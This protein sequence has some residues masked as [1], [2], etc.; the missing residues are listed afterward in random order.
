[1]WNVEWRNIENVK[2]REKMNYASTN[3]KKTDTMTFM[4]DKVDL[5]KNITS[6][7]RDNLFLW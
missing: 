1:M 7:Q 3:Q 4:L 6:Y 5:N 2:V